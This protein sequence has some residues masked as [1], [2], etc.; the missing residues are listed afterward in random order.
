MMLHSE[1]QGTRPCGFRQKIF[2]NVSPYKAYVKSV[3]PGAG[4]F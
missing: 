3:T 1:Y 2:F 4:P